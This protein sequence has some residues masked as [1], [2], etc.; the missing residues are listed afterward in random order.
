MDNVTFHCAASG[1]PEPTITWTRNGQNVGS[2]E[3]LSITAQTNLDGSLYKCTAYNGV[4]QPASATAYLTVLGMVLIIA[5]KLQMYL[6]CRPK[7]IRISNYT[8]NT[9]FADVPSPWSIEGLFGGYLFCV[10]RANWALESC[11]GL[12]RF[13]S[14]YQMVATCK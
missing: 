14:A 2:G 10:C 4:G 8:R 6:Y 1:K 5:C 13:C 12:L 11:V 3:Y 7:T 9:I